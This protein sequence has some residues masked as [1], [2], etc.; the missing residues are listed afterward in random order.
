M[1]EELKPCPFCGG[2]PELISEYNGEPV[3]VHKICCT[4]CGVWLDWHGCKE[5]VI[6]AWNTRARGWISVDER[7]P[8]EDANVLVYFEDRTIM[9]AHF[10]GCNIGWVPDNTGMSLGKVTHWM[11]LPEPPKSGEE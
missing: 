7:L 9:T 3:L 6:E 1:S 5:D 11:P 10:L 8:D 2:E 4:N